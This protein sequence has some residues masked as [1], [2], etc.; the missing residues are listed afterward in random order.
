LTTGEFLFWELEPIR[1]MA[2]CL[3]QIV[4]TDS[5][6]MGP[7]FIHLSKSPSGDDDDEE[8]HGITPDD[9]LY[10]QA[11]LAMSNG[12]TLDPK[13]GAELQA[14]ALQVNFILGVWRPLF[15]SNR[16]T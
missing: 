16:G 2:A 15:F 3:H 10:L 9:N 6:I 8:Q 7:D 5:S 13:T 11:Y 12:I 4:T 1:E 14:A